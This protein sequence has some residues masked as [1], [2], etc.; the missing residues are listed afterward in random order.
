M[1]NSKYKKLT[2][3]HKGHL[4]VVV[5]PFSEIENPMR[6]ELRNESN[7]DDKPIVPENELTDPKLWMPVE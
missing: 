4:Y 1:I 6:W 3:Q 5:A 2:G 7:A